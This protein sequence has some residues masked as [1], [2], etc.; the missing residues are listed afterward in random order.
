MKKRAKIALC[1]LT[2]TI[3]VLS[4]AAC[5]R[6][7]SETFTISVNG[8]T[9]GGVYESGAE[10]TVT[11]TVEEGFEFVGWK[12][13]GEIVSEKNPYTF[14]VTKD[15][16]I[17]AETRKS[18]ETFTVTVV[19]G[20]GGGTFEKGEQCTVTATLKEDTEFV[21]WNVNGKQISAEN[22]YTFE[23]TGNV[24]IEAVTK[25]VFT[26]TVIGGSGS[27]KFAKGDECVVT[28]TLED[29]EIFVGWTVKGIEQSKD[30]P[31]SFIVT[32]SVEITAVTRQRVSV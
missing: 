8:G 10:C 23:V 6:Q 12:V 16:T 31:Y 7:K 3:F 20:T 19:G 5:T 26:V 29:N 32:E 21:G 2:L 27:G 30:N 11:A 9:G 18:T 24:Q 25:Q 4:F 22:P 15:L 1:L 17:E 28:A 14:I 13:G